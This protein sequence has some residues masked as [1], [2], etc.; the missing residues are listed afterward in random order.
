MLSWNLFHGRD[1]PPNSDLHTWR[2]R[3]LRITER[4]RTHAQVNVDLLSRF[5]ERL[6]SASWGVAM[7][8]ECPPRWGEPLARACGADAHRVLTARNPP[9]LGGA[10]SAAA[11][12]IPDLIASWEGG[13]NL[14]LVR[15][16]RITERATHR[17]A[18][19]P[20]RRVMALTRLD[21]GVS[22]ANFHAS[23]RREAAERELVD[24]ARTAAGWRRDGPLA[25]GGDLNLRSTSS[26][27]AFARLAAEHG[28]TGASGEAA[29]DHIL[30][31][32][33][34]ASDPERLEP[35]WREVA[36]PTASGGN[37]AA[38]KVRLSDHAPVIRTVFS[39][40]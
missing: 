37:G 4:D 1:H 32:G 38:R 26:P 28:L 17:L 15:G 11:A 27:A 14:T 23:E 16:H 35:P 2:S 20:E 8:Q 30:V 10:L 22:V 5:A 24:A 39:G 29:V 21:C 9:L 18:R 3:L 34:G 7:L 13:S 6:R 33:A 31:A 40:G 25:F 19:C 12:F 36:D